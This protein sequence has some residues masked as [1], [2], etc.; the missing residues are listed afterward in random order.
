MQQYLWILY[1]LNNFI[2]PTVVTAITIII[3]VVVNKYKLSGFS[4]LISD[5][6]SN[7]N[8]DN[9]ATDNHENIISDKIELPTATS[10][11]IN[12]ALFNN[13][14]NKC[15]VSPGGSIIQNQLP[16]GC[17]LVKN[18]RKALAQMVRFKLR[19]HRKVK[20]FRERQQ[21]QQQQ[22][23]CPTEINQ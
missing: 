12:K 4:D 13:T 18:P 15:Q 3:L 19:F 14:L 9:Y 23:E 1:W 2:L 21:Y 8:K 11:L 22:L 6:T 5:A 7:N 20:R 17:K 16:P 10:S